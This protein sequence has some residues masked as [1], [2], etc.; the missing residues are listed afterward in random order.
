MNVGKIIRYPFL[1]KNNL[2]R[3]T[4]VEILRRKYNIS[5]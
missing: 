5:L 1:Y 4:S 3:L 2:E